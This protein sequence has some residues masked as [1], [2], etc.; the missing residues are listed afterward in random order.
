MIPTTYS[1]IHY[2]REHMHDY[3][4][5]KKVVMLYVLD[6]HGKIYLDIFID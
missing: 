4:Y 3:L 5:T 2:V 6:F 1:D